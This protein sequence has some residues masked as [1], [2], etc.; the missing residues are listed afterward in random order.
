M[1]TTCVHQCIQVLN[2]NN[3]SCARNGSDCLALLVSLIKCVKE[4]TMPVFMVHSFWKTR[5][6]TSQY[7][8]L[9]SVYTILCYFIYLYPYYYYLNIRALRLN[10]SRTN[11]QARKFC[12]IV[13][14]QHAVLIQKLS[15]ICLIFGVAYKVVMTMWLKLAGLIQIFNSVLYNLFDL[16]IFYSYSPRLFSTCLKSFFLHIFSCT[17]L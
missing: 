12:I 17:K 10:S 16:C 11:S 14:Q 2:R 4:A 7:N 13:S 5:H 3:Q 8:K 6:I 15:A 1:F 9:G